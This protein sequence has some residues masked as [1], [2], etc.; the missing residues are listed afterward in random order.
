MLINLI[1]IHKLLE[2]IVLEIREELAQEYDIINDEKDYGGLCDTAYTKFEKKIKLFN[3][4]H[5]TNFEVLRFHGEQSHHPRIDSK[6]WPIQHTW[7][8]IREPGFHIYY[9]DPTSQQF[10]RFYN[11]IPDYYISTKPPKWYYSDRKNPTWNGYT[12]YL[13]NKIKIPHK[14]NGRVVR[15][16]IIEFCQYEIWGRVSDFIR[17]MVI[18]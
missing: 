14:I 5:R 13:N 10:K 12:K 6:R 1:N 16:G 11:D 7:M 4:C 9:V 3:F 15:E 8:G 18:S 2:E 17:R